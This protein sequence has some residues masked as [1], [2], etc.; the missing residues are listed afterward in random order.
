MSAESVA[1]ASALALVLAVELPD[2]TSAA[3]LV[4]T[5]R[6]R[7]APVLA[8]VSVAFAVHTALAVA[9]G[10]ALTLLPSE[11]VAL[12]V[13]AVFG[14]GAFLLLREGI[15]RQDAA[16]EDASMQGPRPVAFTRAALTSCAVLFLAEL[17]D[18]S[19]LA[20]A[21]LTARYSAPLAVGMGSFAALV[22]VAAVAALLGRKLQARINHRLLHRVTGLAYA[23]LA[24]LAL[25]SALGG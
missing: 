8:G 24:V 7:A 9:F 23:G 17:G 6:Y 19:Q 10:S 25:A 1:F 4:L 12:A 13:A 15:R 3:V 16:P 18:A 5:T 21:G 2:K 14:T 20:T 22:L 11:I